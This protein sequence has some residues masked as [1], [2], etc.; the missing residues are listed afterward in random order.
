MREKSKY[1]FFIKMTILN[2]KCFNFGV[3]FK[4]TNEFVIVCDA[5]VHLPKYIFEEGK[6]Y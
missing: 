5:V 1:S 3:T 6:L 4:E 2:V